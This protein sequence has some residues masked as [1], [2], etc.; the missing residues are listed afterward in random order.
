MK[1][2][3]IILIVLV[4]GCGTRTTKPATSSEDTADS[5]NMGA[6]TETVTT[7]DNEAEDFN[8]FFK[9]FTTDSLFQIERVK[10]P[11]VM[12]TW[13]LGEDAPVKELIN[14]EDWQFSSF[15]YEEGYA[16]RQVDAYTQTTKNYGDTVKLEIRGVDNGIHMDYEFAKEKGKWFMVSGKDYSN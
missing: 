5:I 15:N 11:W 16:S 6:A 12:M 2:T 14:K 1:R 13:E 10:F 4:I 3:I 8:V 7:L 9:T